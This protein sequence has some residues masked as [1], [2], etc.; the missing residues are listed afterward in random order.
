MKTVLLSTM[1]QAL[2]LHSFLTLGGSSNYYPHFI[3]EGTM[4]PGALHFSHSCII[5]EGDP[6]SSLCNIK[7]AFL[8]ASNIQL[9]T[10]TTA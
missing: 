2:Y 8:R 9:Y 4:A 6:N 1:C 3:D 5:Y 10:F 7:A